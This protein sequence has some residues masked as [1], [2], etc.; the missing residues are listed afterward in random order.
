MSLVMIR[1]LL[2]Y[3]WL[4]GD[5]IRK[6]EMRTYR[7]LHHVLRHDDLL[8]DHHVLINTVSMNVRLVDRAMM[9]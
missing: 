1:W 3:H 8:V 7:L 6:R 2:Q 5:V 9:I 4:G